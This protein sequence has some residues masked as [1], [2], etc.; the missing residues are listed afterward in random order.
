[1]TNYLSF[2][3]KISEE[4]F[5]G[6]LDYNHQ[7]IQ[8][9]DSST[10]LHKSS[11]WIKC[12][13][14]SFAKIREK[15]GKEFWIFHFYLSKNKISEHIGILFLIKQKKMGVSF[16]NS[17]GKLFGSPGPIIK[18]GFQKDFAENLFLKLKQENK[19]FFV[20]LAPCL[21]DW[22][23]PSLPDVEI[24]SKQKKFNIEISDYTDAPY[25]D[26]NN[27]T[28]P[29]SKKLNSNL[30]RLK[31]NFLRDNIDYKHSVAYGS[32]AKKY[33]DQLAKMHSLEWPTSIFNVG[34]GV[35][36]NF[37]EKLTN[38]NNEFNVRVDSL[39][40][41]NNL[42]AIVF[43]ITIKNRYYYLAPT[44]N[45][46]YEKFSPGSLLIQEILVSL[47][48]EDFHIFD[49]MNSLE[50]YKL[51]WTSDVAKRQKYIFYSNKFLSPN[52]VYFKVRLKFKL[53]SLFF[54]II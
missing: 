13:N 52:L 21:E 3:E 1:M 41:E 51:K 11:H 40:L 36:K 17:A 47:K 35:Y 24:E 26:L 4:N 9:L 39:Y 37:F 30:S 19:Y 15:E 33:I 20:D 22:I 31:R 32:D 45:I 23:A 53:K 25:I 18:D 14:E 50:S 49:F 38:A 16:W 42:A 7:L 34:N 46:Q 8:T 29:I 48:D 6:Y 44:Y 43:G 28:R 12:W 27:H 2:L 54:K 5:E 10:Y